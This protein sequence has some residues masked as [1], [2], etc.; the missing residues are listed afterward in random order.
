MV[1]QVVE[2]SLSQILRYAVDSQATQWKLYQSANLTLRHLNQ[3]R[4]LSSI[5]RYM[6]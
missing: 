1:L 4:L 5:R 6:R 3:L 2:S